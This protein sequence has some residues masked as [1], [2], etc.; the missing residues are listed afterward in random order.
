MY[1]EKVTVKHLKSLPK[2]AEANE[3][4]NTF[5]V[6][7]TELDILLKNCATERNIEMQEVIIRMFTLSNGQY[8]C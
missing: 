1:F 2:S 6:A 3:A 7:N 5:L 8:M 4:K